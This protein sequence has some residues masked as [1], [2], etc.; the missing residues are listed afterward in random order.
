MRTGVRWGHWPALPPGGETLNVLC[1]FQGF[2][3]AQKVMGFR[4]ASHIRCHTS[5]LF[6]LPTA[7]L[8]L[9]PFSLSSSFSQVVVSLSA[10][11]SCIHT[12]V[13][14]SHRRKGSVCSSLAYGA[15]HNIRFCAPSCISEQHFTVHIY[16]SFKRT[17]CWTPWLFHPSGCEEHSGCGSLELLGQNQH[18]VFCFA[19]AAALTVFKD[20][21]FFVCCWHRK[22][23]LSVGEMLESC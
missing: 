22:C 6:L 7:L 1:I 11:V 14:I 23:I 8:R 13:Q 2:Q 3:S 5:P 20:F 16:R 17:C 10:P 19:A 15:Q 21:F 4:M 9:S 18:K 12:C